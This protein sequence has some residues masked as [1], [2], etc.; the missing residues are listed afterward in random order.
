MQCFLITLFN[1]LIAFDPLPFY[2][3]RCKRPVMPIRGLLFF[4]FFSTCGLLLT[5]RVSEWR[6]KQPWWPILGICALHLTHPRCTHT[7][8]NTH[9]EQWADIYSAVRGNNWG[10]G[11]IIWAFINEKYPPYLKKQNLT[12]YGYIL[13]ASRIIIIIAFWCTYFTCLC[14]KQ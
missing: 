9:P 7:A 5:V 11:F 4:S 3:I 6:D 8:V 14:W 12:F 1:P 13:V 2:P 10:F